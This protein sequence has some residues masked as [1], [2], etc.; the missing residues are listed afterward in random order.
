MIHKFIKLILSIL[1]IIAICIILYL[2]S[3]FKPIDNAKV[4]EIV[5]KTQK[6]KD[7]TCA[8]A[9][10]GFWADE[11]YEYYFSCIKG[12]YVIVKYENGNEETV[13]D[14]LKRGTI[15]IED[16]DLYNIGYIKYKK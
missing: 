2:A 14:A 12:K 8:E 3:D 16:L 6:I 9:L 1:I 5:D 13:S 15:T 10:E 11:T 7:F 4:V